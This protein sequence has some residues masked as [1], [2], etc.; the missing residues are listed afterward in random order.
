[1]PAGNVP[2]DTLAAEIPVSPDPLPEK[3][4]A[5]TDPLALI[6][7]VT[8][9]P[10]LNAHV[11]DGKVPAETLDALTVVGPEIDAALTFP[12]MVRLPSKVKLP[13]V[14]V[15]GVTLAGARLVRFTPDAAGKVAGN[16][17][18][19]IVPEPR[20]LAF[21][22]VRLAP[23]MAGS[24]PVSCDDGRLVRLAPD[25]L[26]VPAVTVPV[27]VAPPDRNRFFQRTLVVPRS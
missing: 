8:L 22:L 7:P 10:L 24:A 21:R 25:P 16:L 20:L 27:T 5:V 18:S 19:G 9:N 11:P 3:L 14:N 1:M 13:V 2:A 6:L 17:A 15:P 4:L 23:L 26:N 12:V